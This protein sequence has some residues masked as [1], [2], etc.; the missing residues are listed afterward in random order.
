MSQATPKDFAWIG[1]AYVSAVAAALGCIWLTDGLSAL[2]Q[3]AIADVAAT[4]VIF[5]FSRYHD[6]SS[7]YDAYWSVAPPLLLLFW[8]ISYASF[9]VRTGLLAILVGLWSVRLTYNW[10][11]GWQGLA[12]QDWRY[13]DLQNKTGRWYP[14]LDFFGIQL[15]PTVLVFLGCLPLWLVLTSPAAPLNALDGLWLVT[16]FAALA[17]ETR[18][19]RVL[20][21]FRG[22][23]GNHGS[24]L[25]KDVWAWCRHPNYLGELG[26]W[27][28]L[29]IA[30]Y[31]VSGALLSW[32]GVC[33]MLLLF[34]VVSSPM[35]DK[36]Q[37][38]NKPEYARY[39]AQVASLIPGL[40]F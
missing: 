23:P 4:M 15:M 22:D 39:Q 2:W 38:A 18:A 28:A 33:V 5:V 35:I 20:R 12:H 3:A 27:L 11:S 40:K 9:D 16:G 17:L 32:I 6:N 26:F 21:Q 14:L 1:G 24:V 25:R 29:G 13:V 36:R 8:V 37:L 19:D 30:A 34:I 10:A 7:F 31:G